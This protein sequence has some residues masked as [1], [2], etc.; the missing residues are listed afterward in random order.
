MAKIVVAT[1]KDDKGDI[2]SV[3]LLIGASANTDHL[4]CQMIRQFIIWR[5]QG[6]NW[7]ILRGAMC[8]GTLPI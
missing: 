4:H 8:G 7:Y 2:W 5:D 3:K 6:A 1:N